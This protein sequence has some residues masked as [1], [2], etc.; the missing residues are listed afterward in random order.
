MT[1]SL[2]L[3]QKSRFYGCRYEAN[4]KRYLNSTRSS[5]IVS[6]TNS[7]PTGNNYE[8]AHW[9]T[10]IFRESDGTIDI[11]CWPSAYSTDIHRFLFSKRKNT[12]R[13]GTA[14]GS[15]PMKYTLPRDCHRRSCVLSSSGRTQS[16]ARRRRCSQRPP[17]E[18]AS[19]HREVSGHNSTS[20]SVTR[21][22]PVLR[23]APVSPKMMNSVIENG[24]RL[25]KRTEAHF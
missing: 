12:I 2:R 3:V 17:P 18:K 4:L 21:C 16:G 1:S 9:S 22:H 8:K 10:Y 20:Q 11:L 5:W 7:C 25:V 6:T 14:H 23:S 13:Y 15:K 24:S 19:K